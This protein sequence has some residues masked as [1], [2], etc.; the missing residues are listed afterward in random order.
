MHDKSDKDK[1]N[2]LHQKSLELIKKGFDSDEAYIFA[3]K[4]YDK[5]EK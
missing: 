2:W 3:C 1:S 4:L 5:K